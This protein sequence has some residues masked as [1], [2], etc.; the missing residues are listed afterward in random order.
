MSD[1]YNDNNNFVHNDTNDVISSYNPS[2]GFNEYNSNYNRYESYNANQNFNNY[3]NTLNSYDNNSYGNNANRPIN[4]NNINWAYSYSDYNFNTTSNIGNGQ[5]N[6]DS[7][8]INTAKYRKASNKKHNYLNQFLTTL[9]ACIFCSGLVGG[10]LFFNF[11]NKIEKQN[12]IIQQLVNNKNYSSQVSGAAYTGIT[13][14]SA[15]VAEVSPSVVG[16]KL[17][18][19][20]NSYG[21]RRFFTMMPQ[22]ATLEGSGIIISKDGYIVT[23]YHVV[24]YADPDSNTNANVDLEVHLS[25]GTVAKAAFIGGD[26]KSD[27]AVIK[28]NLSNL[29]AVTFGDSSNIKAGDAVFAIGCPLGLEFQGTVTGGII[30]AANRSVNTGNGVTKNLIQTDAAINEGNSGGALVNSNGELIGINCAKIEASGVEGLGFAIPIDDAK[31]IID[32]LMK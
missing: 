17:N 5:N 2:N 30:S 1:N 32:R 9:I 16:I 6:S 15:I 28:V 3:N 20:M 12:A 11:S 25:D 26:E 8:N 27:L 10:T 23:N 18:L 29:K 31:P 13:N 24:S 7:E 14:T 21:N 19:T 4:D 22:Q